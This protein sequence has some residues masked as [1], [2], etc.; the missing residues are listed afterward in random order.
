MNSEVKTLIGMGFKLN[1]DCL[2]TPDPDTIL[3]RVHGWDVTLEYQSVCL[4]KAGL[5]LSFSHAEALDY[6]DF[7][8][9]IRSKLGNSKKANKPKQLLLF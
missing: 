7:V 3:A 1:L 2:E 4:F 6:D 9:Q 5:W 8:Q